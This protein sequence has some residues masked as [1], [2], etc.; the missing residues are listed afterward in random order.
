[1]KKNKDFKFELEKSMYFDYSFLSSIE[2][3]IVGETVHHSKLLRKV[4]CFTCYIRNLLNNMIQKV[5]EFIR[6]GISG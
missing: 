4:G 6:W 3:S 2:E 5:I 1:M